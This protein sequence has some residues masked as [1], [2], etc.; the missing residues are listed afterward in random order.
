MLTFFLAGFT[1]NLFTSL[2]DALTRIP[3]LTAAARSNSGRLAFTC[4]NLLAVTLAVAIAFLLSRFLDV[5]PNT[6]YLIA[7]LVFLLAGVVYFDVLA[8]KPPRKIN[9]D[10][11]RSKRQPQR[12]TK[13]IGLGFVMTFITMIDDMFALAPLFLD[14]PQASLAALG[15]IY[16]AAILLA[17]GVIFFAHK[18]AAVPHKRELAT[19][20][21]I[22][23]GLLLLF[24]VL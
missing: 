2:D 23:F 11:E 22:T 17:F 18:L 10:F 6:Q 15:G 19:L 8:L 21:L 13:L 14:G 7:G 1:I 12:H 9:A 16:A 4:G 20:S 3:V 5:L 24:G